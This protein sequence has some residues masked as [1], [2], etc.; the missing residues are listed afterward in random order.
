M[1]LAHTRAIREGLYSPGMDAPGGTLAGAR[2]T[3]PVGLRVEE[4]VRQTVSLRCLL[5]LLPPGFFKGWIL[6]P[7]FRTLFCVLENILLKTPIMDDLPAKDG[8]R[9]HRILHF[10]RTGRSQGTGIIHRFGPPC[11]RSTSQRARPD[12]QDTTLKVQKR[13]ASSYK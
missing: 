5:R 3:S 4:T 8:Y 7:T 9:S 6:I 11:R 1:P 13:V 2:A 12:R 10:A